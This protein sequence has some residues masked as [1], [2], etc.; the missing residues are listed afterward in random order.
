MKVDVRIAILMLGAMILWKVPGHRG[1]AK[2]ILLLIHI[3]LGVLK[4]L[5]VIG[6]ASMVLV[7]IV[8]GWEEWRRRRK[9]RKAKKKLTDR[10]RIGLC[11][12]I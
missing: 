6:V 1:Q 10:R 9:E 4:Y 7:G 3:V 5:T 8:A 2:V 12:L 11:P